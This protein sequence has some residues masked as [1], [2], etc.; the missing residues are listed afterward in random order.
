MQRSGFKPSKKTVTNIITKWETHKN[1][2]VLV[3]C[4]LF[5]RQ[6]HVVQ[7]WLAW[8]LIGKTDWLQT[9]SE[10][11][12]D[13]PPECWDQKHV[14]ARPSWVASLLQS[15]HTLDFREINQPRNAHWQG[16]RLIVFVLSLPLSAVLEF[17]P[18]ASDY[19][20]GQQSPGN[21]ELL[22][23]CSHTNAGFNLRDRCKST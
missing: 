10:F 15:S 6:S 19:C 11:Y 21:P 20:S 16:E 4:I 14:T 8:K 22:L 3:Y 7:C 13:L 2:I 5:L 12:L 9:Y 23:G 1:V 18:G 17:A